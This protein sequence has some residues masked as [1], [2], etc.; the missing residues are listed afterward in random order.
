MR[1]YKLGKEEKRNLYIIIKEAVNDSIK[2]AKGSS[3]HLTIDKKETRLAIKIVD[4]GVG[5]EKDKITE[6]NGL[7][8]IVNR[9]MQIGYKATIIS[10]P[11]QGT[12]IQLEKN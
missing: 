1:N 12:T 9:S 4:D 2:Y 11:D 8:N 7:K 5:F 6:G 10:L 3:I